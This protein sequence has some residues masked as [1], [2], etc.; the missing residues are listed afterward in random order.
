MREREEALKAAALLGYEFYINEVRYNP[1]IETK[2]EKM[3]VSL[4]IQN[5]GCA[6]FYYDWPV[7]IEVFGRENK[8]VRTI[9]T[10]WDIRKVAA[11]GKRHTFTTT[12]P[13]SDMKKGQYRFGLRIANPLS[14]GNPIRFSNET[15]QADGLMMLGEFGYQTQVGLNFPLKRID[16]NEELNQKYGWTISTSYLKD[17]IP[18]GEIYTYCIRFRRHTYDKSGPDYNMKILLYQDGKQAYCLDTTWNLSKVAEDTIYLTWISP[19]LERGEYV[20][21][22]QAA[23]DIRAI[24]FGKLIVK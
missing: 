2:T 22:L 18:Y 5:L 20:M 14:N 10:D 23:K 4:D 16:Y 17:Q 24:E 11:D 13:L 19:E 9:T 8:V 21:K 3:T 6:P 15:Q 12:I 7:T 1:Y